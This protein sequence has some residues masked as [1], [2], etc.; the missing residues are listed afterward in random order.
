MTCSHEDAASL[1]PKPVPI[2]HAF[3]GHVRI[4]YDDIL[5]RQNNPSRYRRATDARPGH[6]FE[7]IPGTSH[8]RVKSIIVQVRDFNDRTATSTLRATSEAFGAR[9]SNGFAVRTAIRG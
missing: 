9:E 8:G 7:A 1:K 6:A 2:S 3:K 4:A 5:T